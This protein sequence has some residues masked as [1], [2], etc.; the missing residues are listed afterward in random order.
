M[1]N[2]K[3]NGT[4]AKIRSAMILRNARTSLKDQMACSCCSCSYEL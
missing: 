2:K 4:E 1:A 3:E